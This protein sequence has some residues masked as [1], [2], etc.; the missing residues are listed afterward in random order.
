M[1]KT[2]L[3]D[4]HE[5]LK[6]LLKMDNMAVSTKSDWPKTTTTKKLRNTSTSSADSGV[7]VN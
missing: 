4:D 6:I 5:M 7:A 1:S 2:V 3:K